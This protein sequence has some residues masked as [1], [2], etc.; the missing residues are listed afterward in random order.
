MLEESSK[1]RWT[2]VPLAAAATC[3]VLAAL[4][5]GAGLFLAPISVG[6]SILAVRRGTNTRSIVFVLGIAANAILSVSL[7]SA[8]VILIYDS[9]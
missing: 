5:M 6:L 4:S 8:I 3:V 1:R 2:W 7:V 9:V